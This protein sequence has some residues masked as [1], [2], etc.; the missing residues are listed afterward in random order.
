MSASAISI[1]DEKLKSLGLRKIIANKEQ[2]V[3]Y[4][5]APIFAPDLPGYGASAPIEKNDKLTIG[6]VVLAALQT[7]FKR[8]SS[9]NLEILP[10][11][12]I[13][14]DRG[15]RVVHHL[16]AHPPAGVS[17]K[18][19]SLIDIVPTTIQWEASSKNPA[20]VVGYFH[21]PL[22]ANVDLATRLITAFGPG[23]WCEEMCLRWAGKSPSGLASFK[24]D[25]SLSVYRQFFSQEHTLI[26]SNKDYE[27]GATV[28]V[29]VEKGWRNQRKK[30][31]VEVLVVYSERYIGKRY[32]FPKVWG[33]WVE[34]GKLKTHAL[35][36]EIGHF[37]AEEA[38]EETAAVLNEWLKTL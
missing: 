7:E 4:S 33:E 13:G 16:A 35:G 21:W 5:Q 19:V 30:L 31:D 24:A 3:S 23:N 15:A 17:I 2:V 29:D 25:D 38:P 26:A 36:S 1:Q 32:D 10:V 9:K 12:L 11:V 14:H 6:N 28:D 8:T 20:E 37:G 34:E 18:G 27:A 22:L